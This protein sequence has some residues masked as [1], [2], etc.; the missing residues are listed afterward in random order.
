MA[1]SLVEP[2]GLVK[3]S[4]LAIDAGA[5]TSFSNGFDFFLIFALAA[6]GNGG[7]HHDSFPTV[8]RDDL[9][10]DLI[11]RLPRNLRPAERTMRYSHRSVQQ[12]EIIVDL[13]YRADR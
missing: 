8:L 1:L 10:Q 9:L 11:R 6:A 3:R 5:E 13:G 7:H 12:P 2:D 4:H